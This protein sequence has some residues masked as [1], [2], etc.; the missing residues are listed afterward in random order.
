MRKPIIAQTFDQGQ[1]MEER[2]ALRWGANERS[3]RHAVHVRSLKAG[4]APPPSNR[5]PGWYP[6]VH[7]SLRERYW[8]GNSW[9][10]EFRLRT[11]DELRA[12]L[13]AVDESMVCTTDAIPGYRIVSVLGI[14][15]E[16]SANSGWTAT[17]KG[18]IAL[19]ES[20]QR[21]RMTAAGMGANAIV[22]LSGSPFGAK[23]GVTSVVGGDAV[24]I[25]LLGTAVVVES[26]GQSG[27]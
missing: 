26:E 6:D 22:G 18:N 21:L 23:G 27:S 4:N 3:F 20:L 11:R 15:T 19:A 9:K 12:D 7:N 16:L 24:G 2:C 17:S 1:R 13:D 8:D 25:L 10:D 14:V 5:E